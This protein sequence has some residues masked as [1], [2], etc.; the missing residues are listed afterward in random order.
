MRNGVPANTGTNLPAGHCPAGLPTAAPSARSSGAQRLINNQTGNQKISNGF[1]FSVYRSI[2]WR[3]LS[4]EKYPC[5]NANNCPQGI[6]RPERSDG[7]GRPT[8]L[9]GRAQRV[10]EYSN[11]KSNT[12]TT[13]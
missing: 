3:A 1:I 11:R 5:R 4:T 9:Q 6:A 10:F 8:P 12:P 13:V 2:T 7:S